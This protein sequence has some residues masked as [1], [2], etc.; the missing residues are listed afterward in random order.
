MSRIEND[1]TVVPKKFKILHISTLRPPRSACGE[2]VEVRDCALPFLIYVH[3]D[4]VD[5][6]FRWLLSIISGVVLPERGQVAR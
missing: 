4:S 2:R 5:N 1:H 6:V 3:A